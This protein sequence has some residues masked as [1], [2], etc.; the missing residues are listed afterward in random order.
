MRHATL[1]WKILGITYF[2]VF[3]AAPLGAAMGHGYDIQK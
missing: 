2:Q 3:G 1:K